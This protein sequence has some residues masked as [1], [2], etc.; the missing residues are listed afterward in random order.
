M[1]NRPL[2]VAML[3][4]LAVTRAA[5]AQDPRL[6]RLEAGTRA[7][8]TA[9]LDSALAAGLPAEPLLDR[10]FEGTTKGA[11]TEQIVLALRRLVGHLARARD[12]LGT[13]ASAAELE[14]GAAALRAGADSAVLTTLRRTRPRQ[15][16]TVP[17]AVL[18]DLVASGVPPD[19]AAAT[20]LALAPVAGDDDL[21][22]FRRDVDRD[23]ALGAPPAAAA[24]VRGGSL[25]DA[26]AQ[27]GGRPP[28]PGPRKP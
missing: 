20:V 19:T 8:V 1:T 15:P 21:I 11:S 7:A 4:A 18:A 10:A 23:I 25:L 26:F 3:L 6:G 13:R 22:E 12:A 14:A 24:T 9:I 5:A 16:L 2:R 28:P 17:L 27:S